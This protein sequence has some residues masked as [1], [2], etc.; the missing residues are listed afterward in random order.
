[1]EALLL[2]VKY[3]M[4]SIHAPPRGATMEA[5]L[6]AVKYEMISIHAPPRGATTSRS[7][8]SAPTSNFNSRPSARGDNCCA[9]MIAKVKISIHAPPRG[10][11]GR[12]RMT[13]ALLSISIHAPP[14]GATDNANANARAVIISIHAPP[15]GA[16]RAERRRAAR[17]IFQFTPLRE[18]RPL[19]AEDVLAEIIH[20]NSRPSARG[21]GV[22][23]VPFIKVSDFNSRPSARGDLSVMLATMYNFISIHA[24]PR[25]A[26]IAGERSARTTNISIHAP[27]RGATR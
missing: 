20:F 14:R 24:P 8:R 22:S 6:L 16:T 4:I 19:T 2:A 10:A 9:T 15:R 1:M 27:P 26:T 17:D 23:E 13:R 18:G 25:G 11:T 7:L 12:C 5:L 21:D 3:E